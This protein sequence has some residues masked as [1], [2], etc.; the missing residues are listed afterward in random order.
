MHSD[1]GLALSFWHGDRRY[2]FPKA[3]VTQETRRGGQ[4]L[5]L[6]QGSVAFGVLVIIV[7][8]LL[9]PS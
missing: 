6:R 8:E 9:L 2:R 7:S 1:S 4:S 3:V 5:D